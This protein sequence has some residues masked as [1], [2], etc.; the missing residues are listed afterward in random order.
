MFA[1]AIRL[2]D[3]G[4]MALIGCNN[5]SKKQGEVSKSYCI[6]LHL[7]LKDTKQEKCFKIYFSLIGD[8][9]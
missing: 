4:N 1:D 7:S 9:A 6:I 5:G 8:V 3:V 2:E